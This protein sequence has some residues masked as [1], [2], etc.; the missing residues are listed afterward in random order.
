[1]SRAPKWTE[2]DL[3]RCRMHT[4]TKGCINSVYKWTLRAAQKLMSNLL[5]HWAKSF[6]CIVSQVTRGGEMQATIVVNVDLP[7]HSR[8]LTRL[9]KRQNAYIEWKGYQYAP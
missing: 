7:R 5:S 8:I 4:H 6:G 2:Y 3:D 9:N 1:M